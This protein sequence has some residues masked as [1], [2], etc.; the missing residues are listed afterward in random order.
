[1]HLD[2]HLLHLNARGIFPGPAESR[3]HFFRRADSHP[4]LFPHSLAL[5][6]T[7]K[8]FDAVPDWVEVRVDSKRL[9]PWEGAATW[10]EEREDG[11]RTSAIQ[12]KS[13]ASSSFYLPE[14]VLAHELVHAMRVGFEESRFE[15]ILAYQTSQNRFRR[16]WGPLFT[17]PAEVK[18]L[19]FLILATWLA[20]WMELA[21]DVEWGGRFFVWA[22]LCSLGWG[23]Y[24]LVRS[25]RV[26][27]R[28]LKNI[29]IAIRK[30]GKSLAV[31]LRLSDAEIAQFAT[32]S[33]EE[34]TMFAKKEKE[35]S[36]RWSQLFACYFC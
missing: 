35:T 24:R 2:N 21:F 17:R 10:I 13:S 4:L 5:Q 6:L 7:N 32:C 31:A 27:S 15:E 11:S 28:A 36:L 9:Y 25:Q 34:I 22:P 30:S 18:G 3:D 1:M 20:L 29:E 16:Y 19:I 23:F 33:P 12:L 14:E 26:F 8:L